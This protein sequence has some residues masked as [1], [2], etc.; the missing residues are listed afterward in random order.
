MSDLK[1]IEIEEQKYFNKLSFPLVL[2]PHEGIETI[3]AAVDYI[4]NEEN[5][6][7]ILEKLIQHGAILF[8]G[9][10]VNEAKDFNEFALAFGWD[11][12]PYI[13]GAG[14]SISILFV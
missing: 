1:E 3:Q 9:F 8:R 7:V 4:K 6:K 14:E 5:K 13:G 11:D 12:L 10:P 2:T